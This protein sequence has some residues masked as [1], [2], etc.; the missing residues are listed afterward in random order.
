[1]DVE[2]PLEA[3][4]Q[5]AEAGEPGV[6]TLDHPKSADGVRAPLRDK[7]GARKRWSLRMRSR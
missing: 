3:N 7:R 1:M 5:F 4:A 2:T 6:R